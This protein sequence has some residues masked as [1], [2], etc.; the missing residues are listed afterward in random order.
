MKGYT[1]FSV[2]SLCITLCSPRAASKAALRLY[3]KLPGRQMKSANRVVFLF[4]WPDDIDS[5]IGTKDFRHDDG[6]VGLLIV[7]QDCRDCPADRQAGA[8]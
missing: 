8:V 4:L 5:H 7:F 3:K 6:P 2:D 1:H